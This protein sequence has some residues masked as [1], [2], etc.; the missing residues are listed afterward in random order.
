MYGSAMFTVAI[1]GTQGKH[2][3]GKVA[4]KGLDCSLR[5]RNLVEPDT[6]MS[7]TLYLEA[8]R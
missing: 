6:F 1:K 8:R 3:M 5:L 7:E 2:R 4:C